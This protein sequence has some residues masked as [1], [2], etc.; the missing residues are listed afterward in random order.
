MSTVTAIRAVNH[1]SPVYQH[2]V[3]DAR[4]ALTLS[5]IADVTGVRLRSVQ[6]WVAG[7]TRPEGANRDRLL[8]L[9]YVIEQLGDVYDAEGIEIWMHRPQR[10]LSHRRPLDCL[11]AGQ[12]EAVLQVV[13]HLAGGPRR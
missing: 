7:T 3:S 13:D 4:K 11:K 8:E 6:N 12:F 9:Q 1:A 5:E 2:V 10:L